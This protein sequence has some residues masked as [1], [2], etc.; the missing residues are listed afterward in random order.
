MDS[1][2]DESTELKLDKGQEGIWDC[3]E[4]DK[5]KTESKV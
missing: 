5:Y 2:S 3:Q 1:V 4:R